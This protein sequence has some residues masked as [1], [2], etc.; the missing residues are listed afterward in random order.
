VIYRFAAADVF[1]GHREVRTIPYWRFGMPISGSTPGGTAKP[2]P[3]Q[4]ID[5]QA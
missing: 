4:L 5:S 3:P 1:A 2:R